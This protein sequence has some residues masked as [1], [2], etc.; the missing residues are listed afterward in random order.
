MVRAATEEGSPV[1][2]GG[3]SKPS[4]LFAAGGRRVGAT[5]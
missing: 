5:G 2:A 1:A 4:V 3:P